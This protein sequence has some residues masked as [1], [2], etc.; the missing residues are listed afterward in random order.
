MASEISVKYLLSLMAA[1]A[2]SAILMEKVTRW[3]RFREKGLPLRQQSNLSHTYSFLLTAIILRERARNRF[4][5]DW[6]LLFDAIF[7]H[8]LGEGVLH[9]DIPFPRKSDERDRDEYLAFRGF[10]GKLGKKTT[11]KLERAFLLQFAHK[12]SEIF[13]RR[14]RQIMSELFQTHRRE[15]LLFAGMEQ[16]DYVLYALEQYLR[17]GN[18][19]I[20]ATVLSD[21]TPILDDMVKRLPLLRQLWSPA[22]RQYC[23]DLLQ[24]AVI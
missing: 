24:K 21:Q 1:S 7:L 8:D 15:V 9:E 12:N 23:F 22:F 3:S 14:A 19:E 10:I 18:K 20:F 4:K 6:E 5:I 17:L 13:P 2:D 11:A 16:F